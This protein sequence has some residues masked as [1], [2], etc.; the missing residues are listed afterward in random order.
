MDSVGLDPIIQI[1]A[2]L[3]AIAGVLAGGVVIYLRK[4]RQ[5]QKVDRSSIGIQAGGD[6]NIDGQA[7]SERKE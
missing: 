2:A 1:I 7:K 5:S 4:N 3:G 6:I